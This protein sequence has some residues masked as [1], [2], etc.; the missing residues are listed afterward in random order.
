MFL[1]RLSCI[2]L[3]GRSRITQMRWYSV[4]LL[5]LAGIVL[6]RGDGG[7]Q[8]AVAREGYLTTSDSARLFY[9][10]VGRGRDTLIAIHGGPGGRPRIAGDFAPL[11]ERHVVIF[12]DR[13]GA[14]R[15]ELPTDTTRLAADRLRASY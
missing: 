11:A 6:I 4:V 15:S 10:V 5:V 9:R 3:T 7:A 1:T 8:S 14:G 13:R 12:Y 2:E